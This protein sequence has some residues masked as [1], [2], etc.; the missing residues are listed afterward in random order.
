LQTVCRLGRGA[1]RLRVYD[2]GTRAIGS[3]LC[4]WYTDGGWRAL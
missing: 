2:S 4:R 3:D 1:V